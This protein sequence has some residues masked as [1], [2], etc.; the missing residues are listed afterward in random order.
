MKRSEGEGFVLDPAL[1]MIALRALR[2][3]GGHYPFTN[4]LRGERARRM[5]RRIAR[6]IALP[7]RR[8]HRADPP[9]KGERRHCQ[10]E[11]S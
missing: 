3:P 1:T 5:G 10:P 9:S 8:H 4:E 7:L 2:T 6:L 11:S